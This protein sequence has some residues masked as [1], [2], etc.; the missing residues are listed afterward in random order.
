MARPLC[1][2]YPRAV[3]HV[4]SRSDHQ[5]AICRTE[6]DRELPAAWRALEAF[7]IEAQKRRLNILMQAPVVGGN[8]EGPPAW[9]GRHED[10][11]S[12]PLKTD[13]LAEFAGQLALRYRPSGTLATPSSRRLPRTRARGSVPLQ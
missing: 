8:L 5:E 1:I 4:M 2:E 13:A 11:K 9:A 3:Y 12:A 7:V 6:A 10:G